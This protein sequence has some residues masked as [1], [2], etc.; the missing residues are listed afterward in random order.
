MKKYESNVK[1]LSKEED[2][3]VDQEFKLD[4]ISL[5]SGKPNDFSKLIKVDVK[6][7]VWKR[8]KDFYKNFLVI[9][10][11]GETHARDLTHGSL[12]TYAFH[13]ALS[14][15]A[16]REEMVESIFHSS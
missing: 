5:T 11:N 9:P 8:A 10:Q 12:P 14:L 16:T 13:S 7:L 2:L 3:F 1:T 6:S 15:I 4:L